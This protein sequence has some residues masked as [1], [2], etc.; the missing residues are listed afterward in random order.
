MG[1]RFSTAN[2]QTW[3]STVSLREFER[4]LDRVQYVSARAGDI[5]AKVRVATI[6]G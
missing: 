6:V 5:W 4:H 1:V 2:G 3:E